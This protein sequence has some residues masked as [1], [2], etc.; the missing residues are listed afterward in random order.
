MQ[1]VG[2]R[3]VEDGTGATRGIDGRHHVVADLQAALGDATY[4]AVELARELQRIGDIELDALLRQH[5][6]IADLAAG[7][8]IERATVQNDHG[9]VAGLHRRYRAAILQQ[10]DHLQAAC[11]ELVIAQEHRGRQ[12]RHQVGRQ[13]GGGGELACRARGFALL[14]HRRLETRHIHR[15]TA[16]ARDIG[17]QVHGEAIGVI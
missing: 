12:L 10:G 6:G 1:Q 9:G 13:A 15:E 4:M 17:G 5:A 2:G 7:L 11:V 16:L 3:V 8:R 14:L